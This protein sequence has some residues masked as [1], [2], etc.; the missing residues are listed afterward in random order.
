[1]LRLEENKR[2]DLFGL[3]AKR[4]DLVKEYVALSRYWRGDGLVRCP[5]CHSK[6]AVDTKLRSWS[7]STCGKT[8]EFK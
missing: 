2:L 3:K 6:V 5:I 4:E 1:M 8:G 7:C